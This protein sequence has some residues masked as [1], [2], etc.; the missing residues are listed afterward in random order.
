MDDDD[1]DSVAVQRIASGRADHIGRPGLEE[2]M[3]RISLHTI[4][5]NGIALSAAR[6]I[7]RSAPGAFLGRTECGFPFEN[8]ETVPGDVGHAP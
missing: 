6:W 2:G 3:N 1:A 5:P 4:A 8:A 7:D